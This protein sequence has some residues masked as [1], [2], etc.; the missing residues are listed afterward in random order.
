MAHNFTKE[1]IIDAIDHSDFS[2]QSVANYLALNYSDDKKCAD[3]TA[4]KYIK[5]YRLEPYLN[6][7]FDA[8]TNKA[9]RTISRAIEKGDVKTSKWWTERVLREKFGN[10]IVVHNDNKEPLNINFENFS[11]ED[12]LGNE[13]AEIGGLDEEKPEGTE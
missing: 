5:K 10:E 4:K 9:L 11:K 2:Y 6:S 7:F 1:Q 3:D 12:F 8:T 13:N